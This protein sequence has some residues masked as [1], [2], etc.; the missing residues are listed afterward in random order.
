MQTVSVIAQ[1]VEVGSMYRTSVVQNAT[2]TMQNGFNGGLI[3]NS[4]GCLQQGSISIFGVRHGALSEYRGSPGIA[5]FAHLLV[6]SEEPGE[7]DTS[8]R[9]HGLSLLRGNTPFAEDA[10]SFVLPQ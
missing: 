8:R 3:G 10:T 9:E 2:Q 5:G 4:T 1:D 6:S 7:Y